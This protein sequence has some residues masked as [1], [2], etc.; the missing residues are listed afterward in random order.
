[1]QHRGRP[2]CVRRLA[3][4]MDA[5]PNHDNELRTVN[6]H[7][8]DKPTRVILTIHSYLNPAAPVGGSVPSHEVLFKPGCFT[9]VDNGLNP[10]GGV[11][12][13]DILP[14]DFYDPVTISSL[15]G[16]SN[17]NAAEKGRR[18]DNRYR[19]LGS[20]TRSQI[21]QRVFDPIRLPRQTRWVD[22]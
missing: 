5:T 4:T 10:N 9:P 3:N 2:G 15:I 16:T 14:M 20:K 22:S 18:N 17:D 6:D 21:P 13:V 8:T 12:E 1:M 19:V 11:R 7:A